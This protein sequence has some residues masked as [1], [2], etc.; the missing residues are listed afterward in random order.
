MLG[1]ADNFKENFPKAPL[2]NLRPILSAEVP[3]EGSAVVTYAYPENEILDFTHQ[4]N[5]PKVFSDYYA[6]QFLR[7]VPKPG[8]SLLPHAH[9]ETSIEIRSGASGGPVF[10]AQGR[11]VGVNCRGWDFRGS[12]HEGTNLSSIVP[13]AESLAI[14]VSDLQL[15]EPSWEF[16]QIPVERRAEKLTVA[17]LVRFGHVEFVPPIFN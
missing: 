3:S 11:I 4:E 14:E 9:Y 7:Y 2:M 8:N 15:P 1:Q 10:D 12:E 17:D 16:D 13:I 5:V 6:G